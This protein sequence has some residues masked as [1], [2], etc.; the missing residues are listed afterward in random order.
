MN[1]QP[2]S[3]TMRAA[4]DT[5]IYEM[6]RNVLDILRRQREFRRRMD[7]KYKERALS[8]HLKSVPVFRDLPE[9]FIDELRGR[10]ELVS[11]APGEVIVRQGEE[12]DAFYL[13]RMGHVKVFQTYGDGKGMVLSYLS[14]SQ[15][16]GE[17]GLLGEAGKRVATCSALDHVEVVRIGKDD[18]LRMVEQFPQIRARLQAVADQREAMDRDYAQSV[19][20]V[21]LQQYIDQGLFQAQSLLILDLEKC[22]RCDECVRACAQAHDGVTRLIRD[23]LR[24]DKYLVTTSC[25]S[26]RDPYCMVGCPVGSIRRKDDM[27]IIIEDHCIGCG[28]CAEQCP[29]GNINMHPFDMKITDH[30]TGQTHKEERRKAAVCDLCTDMCIDEYDEPACV[31]ACPHDAAHRVDGQRFFELQLLGNRAAEDQP[32]TPPPAAVQPPDPGAPTAAAV[33]ASSR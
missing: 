1:F 21:S 20:R 23:G 11:F 7:Q 24:Y 27:Q 22:T 16:F 18:F 8:N 2:R 5:I 17:M 4:E 14:R 29:Y 32:V 28:R 31:Y 6:L 13:V 10:V 15:F 26:C 12:A 19:R 30:A 3:A 33:E 9:S 25:R